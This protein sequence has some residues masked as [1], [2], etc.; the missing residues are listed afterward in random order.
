MK[1]L[2]YFLTFTIFGFVVISCNNDDNKSNERL[3]V[4]SWE[5]SKYGPIVNGEEVLIDFSFDPECQKDF[6]EFTTD[7]K[8]IFHE[9]VSYSGVSKESTDTLFYSISGN[10]LTIIGIVGGIDD[11]VLT[12]MILNQTTLKFSFVGINDFGEEET[13]ILVFT[14]K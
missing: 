9:F 2:I 12:V 11:L 4:G 1:N 13:G 5:Y 14:R 3:I 7:G 10:N 6:L 8:A